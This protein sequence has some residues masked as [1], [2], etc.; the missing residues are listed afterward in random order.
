MQLL[1]LGLREADHELGG[2]LGACCDQKQARAPK[3]EQQMGMA[4]VMTRGRLTV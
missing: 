4:S 1:S 2:S 3:L